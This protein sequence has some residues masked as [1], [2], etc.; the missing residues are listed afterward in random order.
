MRLYRPTGWNTRKVVPGKL[1]RAMFAGA[2]E[3]KLMRGYLEAL[4]RQFDGLDLSLIIDQD[5]VHAIAALANKML[6]A[7]D[8]RIEVLRT[9]AH[10][11]LDFFVGDQ[12]LQIT[13]NRSQADVRHSL[14]HPIVNLI[15]RRMR[16]VVFEAI[17]NGLQLLGI[18]SVFARLRHA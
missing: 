4:V 2:V 16:F 11:D 10:Q 18:P 17:P 15:R 12:F 13:I 8:Q 6:V 1:S 9:T 14:S 5:I 7:L 3:G